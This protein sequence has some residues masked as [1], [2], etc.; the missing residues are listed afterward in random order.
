MPLTRKNSRHIR[1]LS[2]GGNDAKLTA[3]DEEKIAG[4]VR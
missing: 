2:G 3:S 4:T 1:A